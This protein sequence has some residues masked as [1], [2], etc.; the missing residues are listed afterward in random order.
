MGQSWTWSSGGLYKTVPVAL[1]RGNSIHMY[2]RGC[3][4]VRLF[5]GCVETFARLRVWPY[6]RVP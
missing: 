4:A 1:L 6:R 5:P 2:M 3:S